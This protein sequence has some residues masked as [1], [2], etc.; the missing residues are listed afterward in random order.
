V[1]SRSRQQSLPTRALP[2]YQ[3]MFASAGVPATADNRTSREAIDALTVSGTS[4]QIR[5]RLEE[6]IGQGVGELLIHPVVIEDAD[7][8]RHDLAQLLV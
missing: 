2:F 8:E 4:E 7:T 3:K 1:R 6:I 5:Q